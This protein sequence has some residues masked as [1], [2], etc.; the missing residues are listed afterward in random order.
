MINFECPK[1]SKK[2]KAPEAAAG[3]RVPCPG[4]KATIVVPGVPK[5]TPKLPP[6]PSD[7][8]EFKLQ[9]EPALKDLGLDAPAPPDPFGKAFNTYAPPEPIEQASSPYMPPMPTP[10]VSS[11]GS[12]EYQLPAK[13]KYIA[14]TIVRYALLVL[15]VLVAI[16]WL[17]MVLSVAIAVFANSGKPNISQNVAIGGGLYL[18]ITFFTGAITCCMLVAASELIKLAMDVQE[19]TLAAA[20]AANS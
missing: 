15:A 9:P 1:C 5:P 4:C 6:P 19:N 3:K 10:K 17:F 7:E 12:V 18:A 11:G 2:I 20:H 13:R 14:L 16:G 8:D